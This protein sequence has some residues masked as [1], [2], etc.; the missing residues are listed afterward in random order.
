MMIGLC[1]VNLAGSH[2]GER[3]E[4]MPRLVVARSPDLA[5][6]PTERSPSPTPAGD[7]RSGRQRC[8]ET[9]AEH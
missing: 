3:S 4:P 9:P 1:E 5:T 2:E 7:L 6:W 8:L